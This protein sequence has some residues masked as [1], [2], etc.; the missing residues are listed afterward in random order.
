MNTQISWEVY[1]VGGLGVVACLASMMIFVSVVYL[2]RKKIR[3]E[4]GLFKA[5][6]KYRPDPPKKTLH[7]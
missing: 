1:V 7:F 2:S 4:W 6:L 5:H 3:K